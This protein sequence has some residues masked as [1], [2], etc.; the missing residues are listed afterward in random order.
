MLSNALGNLAQIV[1]EQGDDEASIALLRESIRLQEESHHTA[2][3]W[4]AWLYLA[5]V[6]RDRGDLEAARQH[7]ETAFEHLEKDVDRRGFALM[8]AELGTIATAQHDFRRAYEHLTSSLRVNQG[9]GEVL[10]IAFAFDRLAELASAQGQHARALHLSGAATKL[11]DQA[12]TRVL[13]T[14]QRDID[15]YIEPSR[16][17]L[18]RLAEAAVQAGRSLSLTDAL[19]EAEAVAPQ[20]SKGL[21]SPLSR[22]EGEVAV[23]VGLGQTNRQIAGSLV[24]SEATVATHIQ[25]ILTKL[26]LH[27]RTQIAAWAARKRL[28][29][30]PTSP[31]GGF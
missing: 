23:L 17:A 6:L 28:L 12:G 18:G 3:T 11:R 13:P 24:V 20:P 31:Y 27:S 25:H 29:D 2:A 9:L 16:R 1:H 19:A 5:R 21:T 30:E 15:R 22:R 8:L 4:P 10:G 26:D 14:D 7:A